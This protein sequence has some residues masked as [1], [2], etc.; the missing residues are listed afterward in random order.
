MNKPKKLYF[1]GYGSLLS[2]KSLEDTIK[3]KKFKQVIVKGYKRVFNL[4]L[5]KRYN[6]DALNLVKS[7]GSK[8]NG[9]I[10]KISEDELIRLNSRELEYNI[11]SV[12]VYD[13]KTGKKI[14]T[15]LTSIDFLIKIDKK[16]KF[17]GKGYFNMCRNAAYKIGKSFGRIWDETT[18]M[19]NGE[20]VGDFLKRNPKFAK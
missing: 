16:K 8:C 19:S 9:V 13:A 15:A 18:F 5:S 4:S 12:T 14:G 2:H 6:E 17:P 11:E 10:F 3:N 20:S 1:F 7:K